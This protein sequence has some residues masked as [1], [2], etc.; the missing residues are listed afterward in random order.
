MSLSKSTS[1]AIL[2]T[3]YKAKV[4]IVVIMYVLAALFITA[5]ILTLVF[6][7]K[8]VELSNDSLGALG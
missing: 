4:S 3:V 1:Q 5:G 8:V 2:L 6:N 7:T